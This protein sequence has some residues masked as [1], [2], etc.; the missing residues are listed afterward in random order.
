M[1]VQEAYYGAKVAT[2]AVATASAALWALDPTVQVALV[3]AV[4]LVLTSVGTFILGVMN[5]RRM[6]KL[7]V[8]VD[9]RLTQLLQKTEQAAS[10]EGFTAGRKEGVSVTESKKEG[11]Q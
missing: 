6:G 2:G 8:N 9:G 10:A 4:P 5:H 1:H 11:G 3:V 7:E